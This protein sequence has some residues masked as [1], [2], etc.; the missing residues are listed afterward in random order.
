MPPLPCLYLTLS[1]NAALQRKNVAWSKH[2]SPSETI[3][4]TTVV[5]ESVEAVVE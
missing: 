2:Q 1:I 4:I 3:I 5:K